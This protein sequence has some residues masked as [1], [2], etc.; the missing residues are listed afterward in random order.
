MKTTLQILTLAF[1]FASCNTSSRLHDTGVYTIKERNG[2]MTEFYEVKG[3]Y[4][5]ISD[6]LK[7]ND[8]IVINVIKARAGRSTMNR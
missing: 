8:K 3:K 6:T 1:I 4:H 5:I 2:S 7:I